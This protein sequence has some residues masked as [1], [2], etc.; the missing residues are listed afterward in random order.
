MNAQGQRVWSVNPFR[1]AVIAHALRTAGGLSVGRNIIDA[2]VRI[3][4]QNEYCFIVPDGVGYEPLCDRAP[5][6]EINLTREM[7]VLAR[8]RYDKYRLPRIVDAFRPDVIL[9]LDSSLGLLKPPCPQAILVHAPQ[10]L[11][12]DNHFGPRT[13]M[14]KIRHRYLMWH[15]HKELTRTQLVLCQTAGMERRLLESYQ[16]DGETAILPNAVSRLTLDGSTAAEMP[17]LLAPHAN[18]FKLLCLTRYYAHKNLEAIVET[19]DRFRE[20]LQDVVVVLTIS[21]DQHPNVGKLLHSIERLGISSN[22][23]NVGP[24]PQQTLA[25]YFLSCQAMFL[26]TLLESFSSTYLEAM[27][28]ERPILTSDIDFAREVCGDAALYFDPWKTESIKNA[29][30][31]LKENKQLQNDLVRKGRTR[32]QTMLRSWDE[33]VLPLVGLLAQVRTRTQ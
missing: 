3:A 13:L 20:E 33:I 17:E 21:E 30:L 2:L 19:F 28:F 16:Y 18:K 22:I 29:I 6:S 23:L 10:L 11:Y 7:G 32:A 4:P 14:D 1:I 25:R 31:S 9:A 27:Q 12:P 26:P 24:L 15:F 5:H 8:L